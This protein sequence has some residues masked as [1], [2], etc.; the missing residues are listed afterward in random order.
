MRLEQIAKIGKR[1]SGLGR[2]RL[3]T[4]EDETEL[5][6]LSADCASPSEPLQGELVSTLRA[7]AKLGG[8][9]ELVARNS[10]ERWQGHIGR[11]RLAVSMPRLAF[12]AK[13]SICNNTIA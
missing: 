2:L 13:L 11:T 3:V 8:A 6:T 4:R 7:V 12:G 9:V 10:A 5:M 1:H